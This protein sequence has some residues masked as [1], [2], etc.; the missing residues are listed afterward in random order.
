[1]DLS[2]VKT[3]DLLNELS[4]RP[5]VEKAASGSYAPYE[6]KGKFVNRETVNADVLLI[7]RKQDYLD[8]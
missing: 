7:I 1:M 5:G 6:L 3:S 8:A 4:N 2:K